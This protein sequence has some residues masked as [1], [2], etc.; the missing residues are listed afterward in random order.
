MGISTSTPEREGALGPPPSLL[1]GRVDPPPTLN[2]LAAGTD[3]ATVV[4]GV[5]LGLLPDD[6]VADPEAA[7][8]DP[9]IGLDE[10]DPQAPDPTFDG[11]LRREVGKVADRGGGLVG[12]N[13]AEPGDDPLV[14][15]RCFP[16][17][18]DDLGDR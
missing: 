10:I 8:G 15:P 2:L 11:R 3:P 12:E 17:A 13:L 14:S 9:A 5:I 1:G 4:D 16:R 18:R 7:V 6:S